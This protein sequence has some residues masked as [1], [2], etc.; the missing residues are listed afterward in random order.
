MKLHNQMEE[1]VEDK[2]RDIYTKLSQSK[3]PW[4]KC[5]CEN[6]ILDATAYVLNRVTPRY[7]VPGRVTNANNILDDR[8]LS[9]DI[10][11]L[12]IE[13]VRTINSIQRPDHRIFAA[14]STNDVLREAM[15]SFNFPVVTGGVF[16]GNTF[17]AISGATVTLKNENGVVRMQD[18]TWENPCKTYKS[19]NGTFNF[20]PQS[21]T[22]QKVNLSK[23]F[24]FI[25]EATAPNYQD[26]I[27]TFDITITSEEKMRNFINNSVKMKIADFIMFNEYD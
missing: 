17:E 2:V 25:A 11:A 9:A 20:W 3:A 19:T 21:V 4:L 8:Q 7:V 5:S 26:V 27:L 13:A 23:K 10:D 14:S 18:S 6:C 24:T 12:S 15:P 22:A 16:D 1:Y